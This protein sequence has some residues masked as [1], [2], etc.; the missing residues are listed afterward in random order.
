ML[1]YWQAEKKNNH[2]TR[3]KFPT[4]GARTETKATFRS[5]TGLRPECPTKF[6]AVPVL[7]LLVDRN[8]S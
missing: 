2:E 7:D 6:T 5:E 1:L 8:S 4:I 3:E